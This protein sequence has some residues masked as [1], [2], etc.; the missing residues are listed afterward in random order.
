MKS[1]PAKTFEGGNNGCAWHCGLSGRGWFCSLIFI[2]SLEKVEAAVTNPLM[3]TIL[4][5]QRM[6]RAQQILSQRRRLV[7]ANLQTHLLWLMIT[8]PWSWT[9]FAPYTW[10][11]KKTNWRS[12]QN[13]FLARSPTQHRPQVFPT[14][15]RRWKLE[16]E[17]T[18][19]L[20]QMLIFW[21]QVVF[22]QLVRSYLFRTRESLLKPDRL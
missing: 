2:L 5:S 18:F 19:S 16:E 10:N 13:F 12:L 8:F 1:N 11:R 14:L 20:L 21:D 22:F 15:F 6:S 7:P 4:R 9:R 17:I 3:V